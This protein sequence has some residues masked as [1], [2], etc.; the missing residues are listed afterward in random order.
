MIQLYYYEIQ[1][2]CTQSLYLFSFYASKIGQRYLKLMMVLNTKVIVNQNIFLS[3]AI[4][5]K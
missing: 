3:R 5:S 1:F 4:S 2:H